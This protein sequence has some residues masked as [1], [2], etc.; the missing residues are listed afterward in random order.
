MPRESGASSSRGL[1]LFVSSVV[2]GSS[3]FADDDGAVYSLRRDGGRRRL[4]VEHEPLGLHADRDA[5]AVLDAAGQNELGE[6][7]LNR[8]LDRSL[9]RARAV[10]RIPTLRGEPLAC[11]RLEHHRDLS[12]LQQLRELAHLNV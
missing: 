7:I 8:L 3:A 9:E 11:R 5:V 2:T 4:A 12:L 1:D 10:S 6:R